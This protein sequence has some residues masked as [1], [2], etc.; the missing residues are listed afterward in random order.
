MKDGTIYPAT[1][2][3]VTGDQL[4]YV[5]S[6]GGQVTVDVNRLDFD[7]TTRENAKRGVKFQLKPTSVNAVPTGPVV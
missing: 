6:Y 7:R 5:I 2:Y 4:H 1:D 3:W